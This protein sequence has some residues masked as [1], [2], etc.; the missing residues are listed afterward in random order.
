MPFEWPTL[1]HLLQTSII[2]HLDKPRGGDSHKHLA[3]ILFTAGLV[4]DSPYMGF[5][6]AWTVLHVRKY[7]ANDHPEA[8]DL[9]SGTSQERLHRD[10]ITSSLI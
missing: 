6:G 2:G 9:V 4:V 8:Q 3:R 5:P 7:T 10:F 1:D